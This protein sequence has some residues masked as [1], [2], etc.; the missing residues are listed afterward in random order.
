MKDRLFTPRFLVV[1][2][3]ILVA[4]FTRLIPHWP[5]FTA[6]GAVALF[7]GTYL[8][9]KYLAF[10]IPIAAM[11]LSD[12]F[13]GFHSTM[14]AVYLSIL[15]VVAIGFLLR[16]R[17]GV[18][19]V[20][21]ASLSSSVIFYLV[22]NFAV[23]AGGTMYPLDFNGLMQCYLMAIPFFQNGIAGDLFY[24]AVFFGGFYLLQQKF[25]VLAKA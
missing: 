17:I 12:L 21:A 23:W 4:A 1:L 14:V 19:T 16:K 7:G 15:A 6:I 3:I 5:N 10:L 13:L 25:S 9:K 2:G 18:A 20:L 24:N 11:L 8:G 22:T